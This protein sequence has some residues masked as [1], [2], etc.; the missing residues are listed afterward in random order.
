MRYEKNKKDFYS[1]EL[2]LFIIIEHK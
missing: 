1:Y 2:I